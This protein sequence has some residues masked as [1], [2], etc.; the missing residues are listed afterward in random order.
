MRNST[1]IAIMGTLIVLGIAAIGASQAES[2]AAA[3][4]VTL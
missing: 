2:E 1:V 3:R 4:S